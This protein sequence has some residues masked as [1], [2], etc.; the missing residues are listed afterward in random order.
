MLGSTV[1]IDSSQ[2]HLDCEAC[3]MLN[4]SLSGY[5]ASTSDGIPQECQQPE[6]SYQ[7]TKQELCRSR[8]GGLH[9]AYRNTERGR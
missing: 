3:L 6:I 7:I 8:V 2:I 9:A 5:R 4:E 1:R